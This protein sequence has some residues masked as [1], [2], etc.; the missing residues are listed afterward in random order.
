MLN[1]R[2]L[3][4]HA[5]LSFLARAYVNAGDYEAAIARAR[6]AISRR[7]DY[8]HAYFILAIALAHSGRTE[9]AGAALR[10]CECISPGFVAGR[11]EW[12]PYTDKSSNRHL[13]DGL[14]KAKEVAE[15]PG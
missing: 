8:P 11:A 6:A 12:Q 15:N 2:D 7:P 10:R 1:P 14:S 4:R 13:R 5:H 9:E 3:Q